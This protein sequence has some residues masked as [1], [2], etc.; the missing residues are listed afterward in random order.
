[1]LSGNAILRISPLLS[2]SFQQLLFPA[3]GLGAANW[4]QKCHSSF[5]SMYQHNLCWEITEVSSQGG[6]K[7]FGRKDY[8]HWW[9]PLNYSRQRSTA[10]EDPS[11]CTHSSEHISHITLPSGCKDWETEAASQAALNKVQTAN[12][13]L[14]RCNTLK[15]PCCGG[16]KAILTVD[17]EIQQEFSLLW[18][19]YY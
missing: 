9:S 17:M 7:A 16:G 6:E 14:Q 18:C 11:L 8:L 13:D 3:L 5:Q 1:M 2:S 10:T 19:T 15:Q 4:A 12:S